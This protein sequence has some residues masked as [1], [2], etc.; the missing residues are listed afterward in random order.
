MRVV[1][2]GSPAFAVPCLEAV[3]AQ[4]DVA[5]VVSQPDK[6]S[7]R[8][9]RLR[10]PAV[11]VAAEQLG[12]PVMQP[13]SARDPEFATRIRTLNA[14]IG[15]VVAYGKI[16]PPAILE[17]FA[18]G[19]INVHA[20]ILPKYRGAAPIQWAIINGDQVT[21]VCIMQL[22]EGMDTGPVYATHTVPIAV[23]E[24]YGQLS[25]RLSVL[26]ASALCAALP[27]IE[28][29]SLTAVAQDASEASYAPMLKKADGI[30]DWTQPAAAVVNR[31]RG[32]DP[33]PAAVCRWGDHPL[34]LYSA[35]IGEGHGRPG[36]VLK[37][38]AGGVHV[39]CGEGVCVV[40][41]LQMAGRRRMSVEEF[42]RGRPIPAGTILE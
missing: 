36:E 9:K 13:R 2:M 16:L 35:T 19:C 20:S 18:R 30:V 7:G 25:E 3:A 38:G 32:V 42:L 15:V 39:A 33:W 5:V 31:I 24:T 4:H 8:G 12:I 10:M 40:G 22:D 27:G 37:A 26:G 14:D 41:E 21:G 23:G 28:D 6:P 34:K 1:F 11:K 29:G 17:A